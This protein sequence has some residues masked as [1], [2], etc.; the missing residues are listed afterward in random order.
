VHVVE[1]GLTL[2][3]VFTAREQALQVG[4]DAGIF[5]R[6]VDGDAAEA[7]LL[8]QGISIGAGEDELVGVG[9]GADFEYGAFGNASL[10][11]SVDV[12]VA[13]DEGVGGK[14]AGGFRL[15]F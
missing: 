7:V 14:V 3:F 13:S 8:G 1:G 11:G 10:F 15:P 12:R 4:A 6:M 9:A 2:P 5:G